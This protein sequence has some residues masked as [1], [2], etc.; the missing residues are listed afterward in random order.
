MYRDASNWKFWGTAI[1]DGE[2]SLEHLQQYLFDNEFFVPHEVGLNHLLDHPMNED[3]L[4]CIPL[5]ISS[6]SRGKSLCVPRGNSSHG[7]NVPVSG[8][9]FSV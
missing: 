5:S 4:F 3:D 6:R 8:A 7:L 2:L 9:G 1:V